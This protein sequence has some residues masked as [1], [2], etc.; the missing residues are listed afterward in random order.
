MLP[1]NFQALF[2]ELVEFRRLDL[3]LFKTKPIIFTAKS[4]WGK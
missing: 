4:K 1:T 3:S 2:S